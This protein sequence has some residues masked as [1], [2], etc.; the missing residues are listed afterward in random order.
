M[1]LPVA[2]PVIGSISN[3]ELF[4]LTLA[5]SIFMS[6]PATTCC[7]SLPPVWMVSTTAKVFWSMTVIVPS[8]VEGTYTYSLAPSTLTE[9]LPAAV[10]L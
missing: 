5:Y 7:T 1:L 3:S 6:Y 2:F 10:S 8:S 4:P 9:S